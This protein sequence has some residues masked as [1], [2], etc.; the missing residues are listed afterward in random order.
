MQICYTG[1]DQDTTNAQATFLSLNLFYVSVP[2]SMLSSNE[3]TKE[4]SRHHLFS[5]YAKVSKKFALTP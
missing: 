3:I 2:V 5:T 1:E 4:N